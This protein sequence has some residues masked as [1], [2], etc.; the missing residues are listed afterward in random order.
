VA[1]Q[2]TNDQAGWSP[3]LDPGSGDGQI[4]GGGWTYAPMSMLGST[5]LAGHLAHEAD[6]RGLAQETRP[7]QNLDERGG[8]TFNRGP[9]FELVEKASGSLRRVR[10]DGEPGRGGGAARPAGARWGGKAPTPAQIE[11]TRNAAE[12][13]AR[14]ARTM[15]T[16]GGPPPAS[17]PMVRPA[18]PPPAAEG[19]PGA[20]TRLGKQ[21]TWGRGRGIG[22]GAASDTTAR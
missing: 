10:I 1:W 17:L 4:P 14:A 12:D 5:S 19:K 7:V 9:S 3:L 21:P 2:V 20:A 13:A 18:L 11:S 16:Q 8:V 22:K 15:V 6:L